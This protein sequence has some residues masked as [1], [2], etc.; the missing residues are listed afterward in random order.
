MIINTILF[1][2]I[3]LTS[4]EAYP[5]ERAP[6]V[7]AQKAISPNSLN[8]SNQTT[9][10]L[11]RLPRELQDEVLAYAK[12]GTGILNIPTLANAVNA[13]ENSMNTQ[14]LLNIIQALPTRIAGKLLVRRLNT[15]PLVDAQEIATQL[16]D[17]HILDRRSG[18]DLRDAVSNADVKKVKEIVSNYDVDLYDMEYNIYSEMDELLYSTY[19]FFVAIS[20][21]QSETVKCLLEAGADVDRGGPYGDSN[22]VKACD[23]KNK[24]IISYLLAAGACVNV[25][26]RHGFIPLKHAV[27]DN[28]VDLVAMLLAA[29]A[30]PTLKANKNEPSALEYAYMKDNPQIIALLEAAIAARHAKQPKKERRG[31]EIIPCTIS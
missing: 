29:G 4:L 1:T 3:F 28:D 23:L 26:D 25:V 16:K 5:M 21:D 24:Q 7:P 22:L 12:K 18:R 19:P 14:R 15:L 13:M 11:D 17:L 8:P 30:N 2:L 31:C 10:Y 27:D 20:R 6:L 9:N